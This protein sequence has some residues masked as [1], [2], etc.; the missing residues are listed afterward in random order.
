MWK[1]CR[2]IVSH[3]RLHLHLRMVV[4][5]EPLTGKCLKTDERMT[6]IFEQSRP[7]IETAPL[8]TAVYRTNP[9]YVTETL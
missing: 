1:V 9:Q 4:V 6:E 3:T 2:L 5:G 8:G 7:V